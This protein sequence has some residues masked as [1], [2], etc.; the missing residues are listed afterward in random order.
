M[1]ETNTTTSDD[2][3]EVPL[4]HLLQVPFRDRNQNE[5][6]LVRDLLVDILMKLVDDVVLHVFSIELGRDLAEDFEDHVVGRVLLWA[7]F[8]AEGDHEDVD[9]LL[10]EDLQEAI[11]LAGG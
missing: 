8:R 6:I 11:A 7:R 1:N 10:D 5:L 2:G 9:H 4:P 3:L